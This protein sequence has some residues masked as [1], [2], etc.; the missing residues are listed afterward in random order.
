MDHDTGAADSPRVAGATTKR[1]ADDGYIMISLDLNPKLQSSL[2]LDL[3]PTD[4]TSS[5][6]LK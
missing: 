4:D 5:S 3:D 1:A 2:P 6:F